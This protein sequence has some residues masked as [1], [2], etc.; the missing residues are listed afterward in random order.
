MNQNKEVEL[1][2]EMKVICYGGAREVTGSNFMFEYDGKKILVDCGLPQGNAS[3]GHDFK[4]FGY[5]PREVDYLI[6]THAHLDHI[7][8][9][10]FLVNQGFKGK[11]ISTKATKEIARPALED[12]F[13]IVLS[14]VQNGKLEQM[15][16]E[17]TN[18]EEAF[19]LWK[20]ID[21]R[22]KY[23]L[24]ENI[25]VEL[26]NS[27]HIL[28]SAFVQFFVHEG[29]DGNTVE[30]KVLF[31]GDMG[32]HSILLADAD[33]PTD[34]DYVF[35]ETVYGDRVHE[36]LDQRKQK[37]HDVIEETLKRRG[38]LVIPAFSIERTQEVLAEI[39][40][41]VEARQIPTVPVYLDSPLG[42]EITHIFYHYKHLLRPD[43]QDKMKKGDDI[44][45]FPGLHFAHT[46]DESMDINDVHGPKIIIAGSGMVQGGRVVHHIRH[47]VNHPQ[48]TIL[49]VGYQ[50]A[51]TYGRRLLSGQKHIYFFGHEL[52]VKAQIEDLHGY[53]AH[54]DVNS[55]LEF[56]KVISSNKSPK[57]HL[58]LGDEESE[59][60]FQKR[61]KDVL[62]IEANVPVKDEEIILE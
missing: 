37:L 56:V 18:I 26:F 9:I 1:K 16:Y 4:N 42:I 50:A 38:T 57:I 49:M 8:R 7:G 15:P 14:Q 25:S 33:I 36:G 59:F 58:I 17:I 30:K 32:D 27:S 55:L 62:H 19:T 35:M 46:R 51:G 31:T 41:F 23:N 5:N 24:F 29:A 11:I 61:L 39:N 12:A 34:S 13:G 40:D 3:D 53:S 10:P 20:S 21:Y 47:Y 43:V 22:E 60:G 45:N 52:E 2:K 44:F 48:N 28:G 54:R 6:V